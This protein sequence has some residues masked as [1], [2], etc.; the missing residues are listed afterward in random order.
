MVAAFFYDYFYDGLI[1]TEGYKPVSNGLAL[2]PYIRPIPLSNAVFTIH[3]Q[4]LHF[5][6][7]SKSFKWGNTQVNS[8]NQF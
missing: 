1:N 8:V 2:R 7:Q 5:Y 4:G 6:L 3:L